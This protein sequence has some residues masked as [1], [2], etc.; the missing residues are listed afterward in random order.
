MD[1]EVTNLAQVKAFDTT[2]YATAAQGATAD[3]A[4]QPASVDILINKT[5][6]S[7]GTGNSLKIGS[8]PVVSTG[9]TSGQILGYDG[10]N[11]IPV[12]NLV[13]GTGA[14]AIFFN[15]TPTVTAA[16]VNNALPILS[17]TKIPVVTA[18][19]TIAGNAVSNTVAFSA[20][21]D[22]VINTTTIPAGIWKFDTYAG[23]NL[24]TA[25]RVTTIT[26]QVYAAVPFITGTVTIT[27]TGTSR[28]ATASA[29]TPF[30]TAAIDAS[31][32]NTTASYLQTPNGIYQITA[33]TSDT[34]VT[35][36]VPT[37]Y[38]NESAVAG[39]TWKK[40]LGAVTSPITDI[41]P[42]YGLYSVNSTQA[43]FSVTAVTKLALISFVTSNNTTTATV[44]Y[45]G[46]THNTS[47]TST[48]VPVH[49]DLVGLQGGTT[50]ENYHLTAAEY[51][52]LSGLTA[53]EIVISNASGDLAS[54]P[55]ATYP[56]L[57][58]LAYVKGLTSAIQTQL[59]AKL[60]L[61]GGTMTG[62][63]VSAGSSEVAKTY[64]P[65]TGA[66]TVALDCALNNIHEV[67]GHASGT[68]I[69]F[70]VANAT[71]SQVFMVSILQGGTTVSTITGWFN[72]VRWPSGTVPTLTATL[73]KRDT[74]GFRRTGANTYD[75]FVI[76]A[77]H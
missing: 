19:Q 49:N 55:V 11:W 13:A 41:S 5:F 10:T 67:S 4:V 28:T 32:T 40:L 63:I 61:A 57:A 77:N 70:T 8:S 3:T 27:G 47:V 53:S 38:T 50:N 1:S 37:T 9:Q 48:L 65:A 35:I 31:A 24:T 69:T 12:A 46:T 68:A 52:A 33:R 16:G 23:V 75:G 18:E 7:A 58:E 20:W 51:I 76:G 25:G 44:A 59:D 62:K 22:T 14:G 36:T 2:D 64:T 34:V 74:F 42:A 54:A 39:S 43:A 15:A 71:N 60:A 17:L 56:S 45:N 72:T 26:R 73:N 66:Q 21:I 30:E 6:D 29:G